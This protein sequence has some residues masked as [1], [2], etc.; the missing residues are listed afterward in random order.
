MK[1]NK[2]AFTL[3]E[4]LVVIAIIAILAAI[5]FPVFAQAKTAAK[6]TSDLSNLK[7][8]MTAV[9]IYAT[10]YDDYIPHTNWQDDYVFAARVLPYTKNKQ[11][12]KSPVSR[13]PRG[14]VQ[15]QKAENGIGNFIPDPNDGCIGLGVSTRGL[16]NYYDDIYPAMDYRLNPNIFGYDGRRGCGTATS[17]YFAPAP[18]LTAGTSG[19]EGIEG[20]GPGSLTFENISRVVLWY[21]FPPVGV[22]WPGN[23][24]GLT[25]FWG[26][27]DGNFNGGNNLAYLDGHA[28]FEKTTKM[29]PNVNSNGQLI[30]QGTWCGGEG[31]TCPYVPGAW[32]DG[33]PFSEQNGRAFHWWGTSMAHPDFR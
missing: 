17:G 31:S 19:G 11:I 29:L 20:F 27:R 22:I 9:L 24:S 10:D 30:N 26:V 15:R 1:L 12:F 7:Q 33:A 14:S 5:L 4:L 2:R 21:N 25:G 28:G 32:P 16:A 6:K 3:I 13:S 8:N 18:N 23:Q